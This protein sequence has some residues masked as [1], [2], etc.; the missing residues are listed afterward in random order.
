MQQKGKEGSQRGTLKKINNMK[1]TILMMKP[2]IVLAMILGLTL[3]SCKKG[4]YGDEDGLGGNGRGGNGGGGNGGNTPTKVMGV[5]QRFDCGHS[6]YDE[7]LWIRTDDGQLLQPC[8]QSFKTICPIPLKDGDRVE[9]AFS[10]YT[11]STKGFELTC[12]IANLEF[13]RATI[14]F[15]IAVDTKNPKGSVLITPDY[16]QLETGGVHVMS[17][18][19]DGSQLMLEAAFSGCDNSTEAFELVGS[20]DLYNDIPTFSLKLINRKPEMCQAFFT[21]KLSFDLS[22]LKTNK[23]GKVRIRIEGVDKEII[24]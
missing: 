14:D 10:K 1:K 22:S 13:T 2:M 19:M 4:W 5:I 11:G 18:Q 9:L 24:F 8:E 6:I 23:E 3:G 12:K 7:N 15:I 21:E 20:P 17:A 16:D